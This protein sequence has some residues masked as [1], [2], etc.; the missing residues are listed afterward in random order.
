MTRMVDMDVVCPTCGTQENHRH[1]SSVNVT[2]DPSLKEKVFSQ[3]ILAHTCQKCNK[4]YGVISDILYHDMDQNLMIYFDSTGESDG[5]EALN[6]VFS[7]MPEAMEIKNAY[8][9]RVVHDYFDMVEKIT[10]VDAG[11]DD[12]AIEF[13][14][15]VLFLRVLQDMSEN[16]K[17][18]EIR[19]GSYEQGEILFYI[20]SMGQPIGESK[21]SQSD[22]QKALD[23]VN[24]KCLG[25]ETYLIDMN[26][27][28][29]NIPNA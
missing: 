4:R 14:K 18:F 20:V 25:D 1:Y 6:R 3:E 27:C 29:R 24:E 2:I 11:L 12:R 5:V 8:T 16:I 22:Y 21:L 10:V 15:T 23:Y 17:P 13:L 26:W 9:I 7:V 28:L 19:Y